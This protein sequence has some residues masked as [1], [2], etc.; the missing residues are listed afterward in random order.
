MELI[1]T[2]FLFALG[3]CVGSFLNVVI[4]RLPRGQSV[5]F[6]PRSFCP[7]C[8]R[9][10]HGFDNIPLV[11]WFALRGRCRFCSS[12]ISPQYLIVEAVTAIMVAGLYVCYFLVGVRDGAGSFSSAWPMFTAHAAL[13]C[14]L[15]AASIID[16]KMFIIPL[17]VMWVCMLAGLVSAAVGPHPFMAIVSAELIGVSVAAAVG[18][19]IA[20]M[21]QERGFLQPSFIDADDKSPGIA[22]NDSADTVVITAAHG[23][24]P[25]REVLRELLFLTPAIVLG[26]AALLLLR[27]VPAVGEPWARMFD[28]AA[29]PAA[30]PH[31]S[32]FGSALFG[33][34]VGGAW[35]WSV[36]ILGTLGFGK[37][38]MGLGD[39]YILAAVGAVT[40]WL[41]PTIAFFAAPFLGL[42][43]TAA[44][45]MLRASA[46]VRV[47][48]YGPSLAV[49]SVLT[50]LFYDTLCRW[51][52]PLAILN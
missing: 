31:L 30:A 51:L 24:N 23:V 19:G 37:E 22:G 6:P 21:L 5:M 44:T 52:A 36:R 15:L 40:G 4:Y 42:M 43:W 29:H 32:S 47:L 45:I 12:P 2:V 27:W 20:A 11:S 39:V 46:R 50:M 28:S 48:P 25:R 41:I 14:G 3:A 16:V 1:W 35:I 13:L 33:L 26:A 18:L 8:G 38:A 7:Y 17:E 9:T 34:L 10:I 49:A